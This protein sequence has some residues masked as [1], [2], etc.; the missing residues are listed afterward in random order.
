MMQELKEQHYNGVLCSCCRQPIPLPA[1]IV[2]MQIGF[3]DPQG[4]QGDRVFSLRCRAC[5]REMP[6]RASQVLQIEGTP[7][8][9]ASR[10]NDRAK[11]LKHQE[12]MSRAA[13]G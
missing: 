9:R 3:Y 4:K 7:R 6:Y 13:N 11:L 5:E 10:A 12:G 1:I 2:R 8:S